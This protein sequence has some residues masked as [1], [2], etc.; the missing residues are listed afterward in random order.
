M[1]LRHR[2]FETRKCQEAGKLPTVNQ[3][4]RARRDS[5]C[6]CMACVLARKRRLVVVCALPYRSTAVVRFEVEHAVITP[7]RQE[8]VTARA[9]Q[10]AETAATR[11][12]FYTLVRGEN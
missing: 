3:G 4:V 12:D 1:E 7:L 10:A 2:R 11:V 8:L 5:F 9:K 6:L